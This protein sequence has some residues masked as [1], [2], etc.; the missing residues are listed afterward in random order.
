MVT[1]P[2]SPL[3]RAVSR[4][5]TTLQ[6]LSLS[7]YLCSLYSV[8]CTVLYCTHATW[9]LGFYLILLCQTLDLKLT[10]NKLK[11]NYFE[12]QNLKNLDYISIFPYSKGKEL[13]SI[14][15]DFQMLLK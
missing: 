11:G 7:P 9:R 3:G 5:L 1:S 4:T 15:V 12:I 10:C 14:R 2:L 8:Q 6:P 13:K